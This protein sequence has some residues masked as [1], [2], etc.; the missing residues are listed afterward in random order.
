M[1]TITTEKQ[2]IYI[3]LDLLKSRVK[4]A[5]LKLL[6]VLSISSGFCGAFWILGMAGA[7]DNN[8]IPFNQILTQ[9]MQG[10]IFCG[11][12]YGL[13]IIKKVLEA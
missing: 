5:V 12:G 10:G 4:K 7:S 6:K 3:N 13:N 11:I 2:V 8:I 1:L 9:L